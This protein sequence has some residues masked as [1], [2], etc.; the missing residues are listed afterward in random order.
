M[1][2]A[3]HAPRDALRASRRLETVI[4]EFRLR[5]LDGFVDLFV[6]VLRLCGRAGSRR[7]VIAEPV[8][9]QAK[10]ARRF[11]RFSLR[12]LRKVRREWA[13]L[14]LCSNLLKLV[15]VHPSLQGE[16]A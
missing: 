16:P 7:K 6:Q 15:N 9:G 8:F 10:E 3:P 1:A 11:R 2:S 14:C 12:G 13:F 4:N 5:H